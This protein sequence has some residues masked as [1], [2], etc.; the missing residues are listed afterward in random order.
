MTNEGIDKMTEY[1]ELIKNLREEAEYCQAI[2]WD[3]P[4]C[5]EDHIRQAADVIEELVTKCQR[6]EKER[7]DFMKDFKYG[8]ENQIK[9]NRGPYRCD[10]CKYIADEFC[11]VCEHS[12]QRD[13]EEGRAECECSIYDCP[14]I[15]KRLFDKYKCTIPERI[16]K[17]E[18]T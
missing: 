9:R 8:L 4:L 12:A 7:D 11:S 2:E 3:I 17:E 18:S 6:L 15:F 1:K 10:I 16:L 14:L 5:T 13:D